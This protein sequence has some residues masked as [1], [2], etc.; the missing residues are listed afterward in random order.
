MMVLTTHLVEKAM[1]L[2]T[3][4]DFIRNDIAKWAALLA[5]PGSGK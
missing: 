5:A 3:P 1:M 4:A 2:L